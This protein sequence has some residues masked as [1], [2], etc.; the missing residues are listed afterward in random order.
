MEHEPG[1]RL[2]LPVGRSPWAIAAG[3]LGLLSFGVFP[4][5]PFAL[6]TGIMALRDLKGKPKLGG[7]G[8]AWLGVI[9]G[10][11]GT[12]MLIFFV[13]VMIFAPPQ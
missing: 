1:M 10:T 12:L 5:G 13:V 2:L 11:L 4:L 3:Y 8:R 7:R 9:G 6:G